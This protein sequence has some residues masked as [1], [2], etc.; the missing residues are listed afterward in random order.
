MNTAESK[1]KLVDT[2]NGVRLRVVIWGQVETHKQTP[3]VLVH[4]LASNAMLWEGAALAFCA[5]GHLVV[6]VDL[7]GHGL[8]EKPSE[9]YD[10]TTVTNDLAGLLGEIQKD[11]FIKPIVCGQSWGGNVVLELAHKHPEPAS[12]VV[13]VDGGFI[14][15]QDHYPQWEQCATSLRP[16]TI[17]GTRIADFQ[18]YMQR[19]HPDWPATG[20]NGALACMEHL[21][22]GT[23]RPWLSLERHMLILRGLWDH[24]PTHIYS[25]VTLPVML[26]PAEGPAGLFAKTKRDAISV[27]TRYLPKSR[28]EWFSPADHDLHAQHPERFAQAVHAAITDGFFQ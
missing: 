17:T 22:D 28:V 4:G 26:V 5:L 14:E 7:R 27:A 20:I 13:C 21:P 15:L 23:L 1:S 11:G 3:I 18:N 25:Q 2:L 16:P 12:G 6:A 19:G 9:G 8:S 10:M 24:H